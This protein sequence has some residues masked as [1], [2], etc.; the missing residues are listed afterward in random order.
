MGIFKALARAFGTS[1]SRGV[2]RAQIETMLRRS[3]NALTASRLARAAGCP[4]EE[5]AAALK[6]M[7]IDDELEYEAGPD[8]LIYHK[9][10]N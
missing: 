10:S 8:E 2:T 9:P 3:G 4:L 6:R 5:A 1:R 7:A